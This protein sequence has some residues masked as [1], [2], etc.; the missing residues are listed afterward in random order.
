[1]RRGIEPSETSFHPAADDQPDGPYPCKDQVGAY[2]TPFN[3]SS[4][5]YRAHT[6]ALLLVYLVVPV[7]N[8]DLKCVNGISELDRCLCMDD[9]AGERCERSMHCSTFM[10]NSNGR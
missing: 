2:L 7:V 5:M 1:M 8:T 9:Y 10:R 6:A 3:E 4:K